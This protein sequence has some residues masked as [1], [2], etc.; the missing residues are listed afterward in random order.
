MKVQ[1]LWVRDF[2]PFLLLVAI[3]FYPQHKAG[4]AEHWGTSE[5]VTLRVS[6]VQKEHIWVG[7]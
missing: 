7:I 5:R 2:Q 1:E 3:S 6:V 4:A